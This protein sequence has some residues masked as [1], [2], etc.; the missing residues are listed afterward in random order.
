M[1]EGMSL[2]EFFSDLDRLVEPIVRLHMLNSRIVE[3]NR[4]LGRDAEPKSPKWARRK[5][6]ERRE[7]DRWYDD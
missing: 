1:T 3:I 7:S 5:K 6:G 4:Q 2:D